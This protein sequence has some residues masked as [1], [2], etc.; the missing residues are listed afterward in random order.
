MTTATP[1][2]RARPA[3]PVV[4]WQSVRP[5]SLP[6]AV[7]S[8]AVGSMALLPAQRPQPGIAALCALLA[9]LLQCGTNV[10]NDAEDA[11]TGADDFPAAGSSLAM[12]SGWINSAR[13]RVIAALCFVLAAVVGIVIVLLVQKPALL[14][15]GAGA[16][17][18][19]WAYT[20]WPLRLAY[21]PLGELA[22]ALPMGIGI[23][24]GTAAAQATVVPSSVWWAAVPLA[25][26]TAAILHAN[27]ARDRVHDATVGK[28]TLATFLPRRAVVWEF[29]VLLVAVPLVITAGL[30]VGA[31]PIWTALAVIPG[32]MAIQLSGKASL[33]LDGR[34]WTLLL[35]A[36]VRLH[37]LTGLAL[38]A[39][40]A[41]S[42][43]R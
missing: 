17:V 6:I 24:W 22:S 40:F 7:L 32:L 10:L 37:L 25:L 21:R 13:A 16:L 3:L 42:L 18:V 5:R 30:A 15:L 4:L 34:G 31:L 33:S 23:P 28:R 29:Q 39:G 11:R 41:L 14:W 35:I 2:A 43:I 1:P 19:G 9:V 20:A 36:T 27:N 38:C 26:L 12:R 8:S